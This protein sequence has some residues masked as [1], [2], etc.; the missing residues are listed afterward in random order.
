M[1]IETT[2][3]DHE[4]KEDP[5]KHRCGSYLSEAGK[6]MDIV[7][8]DLHRFFHVRAGLKAAEAH[9]IYVCFEMNAPELST[10]RN[11]DKIRK[12]TILSALIE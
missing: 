9:C 12:N 2:T 11:F 1:Q 3:S 4:L 10:D 8:G 5:N 7:R 6:V